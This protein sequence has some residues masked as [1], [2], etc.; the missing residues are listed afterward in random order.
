MS[1]ILQRYRLTTAI[2]G[3]RG[4]AGTPLVLIHGVGLRAEAWEEMALHLAGNFEIMAIDLPGHGESPMP[5]WPEA[6]LG[7]YG[8]TI[9]DAIAAFNRPVFLVGHS[10]GALIALDLAIRHGRIVRGV[11][12]LNCIFRRP[13]AARDAVRLRAEAISKGEGS[14]PSE[15]I[16]RWFGTIPQKTEVN[17]ARRCAQWLNE[18][19]QNAY[20]TAYRIFASED[21]PSEAALASLSV[22]AL[23]MTGG[24]E[25]NST[26]YMSHQLA[27]CVPNG[28]AVII[29]GARH[30]LPMTHAAHAAEALKHFYSRR[31]ASHEQ[32]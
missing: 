22:P 19:D 6:T 18:V 11:A 28:E 13:P 8:N 7:L 2:S 17:A 32:G 26:P 14:D 15:T 5:R 4:G 16:T 25:P 24:E 12:A 27:R 21:G 20:A 31:I 3:L 10:L 30:M 9:A 23:F 29:D 1:T